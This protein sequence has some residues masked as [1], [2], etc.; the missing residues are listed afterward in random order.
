MK[1]FSNCPV[2]W[3]EYPPADSEFSQKHGEMKFDQSVA[4][5]PI[6]HFAIAVATDESFYTFTCKRGHNFFHFYDMQ[7]FEM[8]FASAMHS[9]HDSHL[10]ETVSSI[11]VS[12]ERSYEFAIKVLTHFQGIDQA[13]FDKMWKRVAKQS[14]RQLGAFTFLY[15]AILKELPP[16]TPNVE[17]RNKVVHQGYFPKFEETVEYMKL[18][19][20]VIDHI[21]Q[22]LFDNCKESFTHEHIRHK[23]ALQNKHL[24]DIQGITG[25]TSGLPQSFIIPYLTNSKKVNTD[26]MYALIF[27]ER[28]ILNGESGVYMAKK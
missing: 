1:L 12:I 9:F 18:S 14:E 16:D 6:D 13:L 20:E 5:V 25:H 3:E 11:A 23:H 17:L 10:R 2:C 27:Q 24:K 7:K 4:K 19:Y 15:S 28:K 26:T 22:K 21:L 8:L